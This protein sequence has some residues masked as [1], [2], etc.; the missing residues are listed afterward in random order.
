MLKDIL[1]EKNY[2]IVASNGYVSFDSGIKPLIDK[3]NEDLYYFKDLEV[4][5]KI[6]GK[7]AAMLFSL[8]GVKKVYANVLSLAGKKILEEN[9]IEYEYGELVDYIINRKGDGMCP[10]EMTVKE[11]D[12]PKEA[13]TALKNKIALH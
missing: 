11:I 1:L 8:S 7:A 2:S 9:N 12:D 6:V 10:M 13:F 3:L 4:A 5:D